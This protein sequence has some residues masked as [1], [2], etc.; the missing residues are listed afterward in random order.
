MPALTYMRNLELDI[1]ARDMDFEKAM[2]FLV[3]KSAKAPNAVAVPSNMNMRR[4]PE[5]APP[6]EGR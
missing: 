2:M 6:E 1:P 3:S 5:S 4:A